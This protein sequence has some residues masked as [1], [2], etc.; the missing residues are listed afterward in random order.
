MRDDEDQGGWSAW[1]R[2]ERLQ[3]WDAGEPPTA[4]GPPVAAIQLP[5]PIQPARPRRR[6]FFWIFLTVQA[7][8]VLWIVTGLV[9]HNQCTNLSP[10]GCADAGNVAHG[11]AVA[12]Q[13]ITW[14]VVDFLV[15]GTYAVYRLAGRRSG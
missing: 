1:S 11:L 9:A 7:M 4:V 12:V 8:F 10:R 14:V 3:Q 5:P 13:V 2:P 6:V 15:G